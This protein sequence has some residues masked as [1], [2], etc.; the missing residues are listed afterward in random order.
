MEF[1]YIMKTAPRKGVIVVRCQYC[2]KNLWPLR[3]LFDEDFCSKDHRQRY[4]ERVRKALEHLPKAQ[5]ASR[6]AVAGFQ[7]EK[8]RVQ[9]PEMAAANAVSPVTAASAGPMTPAIPDFAHA[10]APELAA[11]AFRFAAPK[12]AAAQSRAS[13]APAVE[14]NVLSIAKL[15]ERFHKTQSPAA[16]A[17]MIDLPVEIA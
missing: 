13:S 14:P 7:F 4:H 12:A 2:G 5:T 15:R 8:P 6:P 11:S 17:T 3:G 10:Q 1:S 9:Q 16:A